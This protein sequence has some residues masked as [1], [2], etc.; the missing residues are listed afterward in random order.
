MTNEERDRWFQAIRDRYPEEGPDLI[1]QEF[2]KNR[3][4]VMARASSMGV[5]FKHQHRNKAASRLAN[6]DAVDLSVLRI[7]T[8]D[9]AY[10][11]GFIYADGSVD[12]KLTHIAFDLQHQDEQILYDIRA[13][14]KSNHTITHHPERRDKN[15]K[16]RATSRVSFCGKLL[17]KLLMEDHGLLPRKSYVDCPM[18]H[19]PSDLLCHFARGMLD[20][21]GTVAFMKEGNPNP[22]VRWYGTPLLM[23][24]FRR[25]I[26]TQARVSEPEV[27]PRYEIEETA[28]SLSQISWYQ[29]EDLRRLYRWLY[30][31]GEYLFLVRKKENFEQLLCS[32]SSN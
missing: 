9:L 6:Y 10:F 2:N 14:L 4:T 25:F 30:P 26:S 32:L 1:A 12:S 13:F 3:Q 23:D 24:S 5:K 11:L 22:T 18:P 17:V 16:K 21:D 8:P 29:H 19:I 28:I 20:G 15:G 7:W 27:K 31:A